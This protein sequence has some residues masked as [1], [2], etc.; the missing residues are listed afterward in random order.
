FPVSGARRVALRAKWR[1]SIFKLELV[2]TLQP[3]YERLEVRRHDG[4]SVVDLLIDVND[5]RLPVRA[6]LGVVEAEHVV[7]CRRAIGKV[8]ADIWIAPLIRPK[9]AAHLSEKRATLRLTDGVDPGDRDVVLR[10]AR[11]AGG[12]MTCADGDAAVL[13]HRELDVRFR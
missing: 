2:V 5:A 7:P 3:T 13:V 10:P 8:D 6:A 4:D 9:L 12:A 11:G 1:R